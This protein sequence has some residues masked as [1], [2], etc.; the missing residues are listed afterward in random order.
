M[1]S[2]LPVLVSGIVLLLGILIAT[3]LTSFKRGKGSEPTEKEA[4]KKKKN[5]DKAVIVRDANKRLAQ[6]PKDVEALQSLS[7]I[8]FNDQDWEKAHKTYA[9]LVTMCSS[10]PEIDEFLVT[11]RQAISALNLKL[12]DE[13]YKGLMIA[14]TFNT[15][16]FE[17]NYHLGYLEFRRKNFERAISNLSAALKLQAGHLQTLKYLG[18]AY[19][20]TKRNKEAIA[21]LKQVIDQRP[22]DKE[23]I[24]FQAQAYYEN[25]QNELSIQLFTHLRPDP[26]FGPQSA[27]MAGSLHMKNKEYDL[28]ILDF[29]LGLRHEQIR[30]EVDLELK[31]R[32][33]ASHMKLQ[34][35]PSAIALLRKIHA[36]DPNYKDVDAQLKK[37]SELSQNQN[38]QTYLIAQ[39][40]DFVALCRKMS[41]TYFRNAHTKITDIQVRKGEYADILAEVETSAWADVVLFRY[42]RTTGQVGEF[43]LRDLHSRI[44]ELKAG[45]GFCVCAGT[46]S[47]GALAFV[48]ARFID[49]ID[50]PQ[51]MKV[52]NKI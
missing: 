10:H 12:F 43:V 38:L 19:C 1:N 44:K 49:L 33:A 41:E 6:N 51:L 9:L 18:M 11:T 29:E 40:A 39:D 50:K 27:L 4:K 26:I 24:Y 30:P 2:L 45:R 5:R 28:A 52:L 34:D 15:E 22:D 35:V 46:F 8:Y 20:K 7:D 14:R 48:E 17:I 37:N 16:V 21:T 36:V 32:L 13:A 42:V 25:G 31:Y 23:A 47:E 3:V